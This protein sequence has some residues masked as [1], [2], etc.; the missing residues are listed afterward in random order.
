M[1]H[2]A[3]GRTRKLR[4][5]FTVPERWCY[6]AGVLALAANAPIRGRLL[7]EGEPA[8]EHDVAE[9]A[10][11]SVSVAR[12][13]LAKMR[14]LEMLVPDPELDCERVHDWEEHNPEPSKD[15][16]AP[17]R[18]RRYREKLRRNEGRNGVGVTPDA[19]GALRPGYV[20]EVEVEV[21]GKTPLTPRERGEA[22]DS[23]GWGEW[24]EHWCSVTGRRGDLPGERTKAF[25]AMGAA[26]RQRRREGYSLDDLKL[27]T[28]GAWND[29]HR[30]ANGYFMPDS[31]LRATK[32]HAL[33]AKGR[34]VAEASSRNGGGDR[35]LTDP[36]A[37]LAE[38][39]DRLVG[40]GWPVERVREASLSRTG[41]RLAEDEL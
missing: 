17:E 33:V 37:W 15:R 8:D 36:K 5:H 20:H 40:I 32:V 7:V 22:D 2:V 4:R 34:Q 13:T 41:Q 31:V 26:F 10:D 35:P 21:E 30:R 1:V 23:L 18:M 24:L 12:S 25:K 14:D 27:A 29:E 19:T 28:V 6:V 38:F 9:Q 11:V 39:G 16:T 3:I